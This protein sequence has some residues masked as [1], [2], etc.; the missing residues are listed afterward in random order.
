[1]TQTVGSRENVAASLF[2]SSREAPFIPSTQVP[3]V[4]ASVSS[5][6]LSGC[7]C[8]CHQ[9]LD[10]QAGFSLALMWRL[11]LWLWPHSLFTD[12]YVEAATAL[13]QGLS[14]PPKGI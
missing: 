1:M 4:R 3:L 12:I 14:V 9:S 11:P 13:V 8:L 7:P 2:I 5:K 10:S 6:F